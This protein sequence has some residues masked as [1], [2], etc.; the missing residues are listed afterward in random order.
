MESPE[1]EESDDPLVQL[2]I[3]QSTIIL[4]ILF[5]VDRDL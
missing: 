3:H 4:S 1:E 5:G 2:L